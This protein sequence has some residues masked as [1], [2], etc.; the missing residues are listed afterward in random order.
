VAGSPTA[1]ADRRQANRKMWVVGGVV[2]A[3]AVV[4]IVKDWLA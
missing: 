1:R 2:A 3:L 4:G